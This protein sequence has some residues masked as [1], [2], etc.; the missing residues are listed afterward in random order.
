MPTKKK[1][2]KGLPNLNMYNISALG[3]GQHECRT[4]LNKT[5]GSS[6]ILTEVTV[7]VGLFSNFTLSILVEKS[8]QRNE[9]LLYR[10][11]FL[12]MN[13]TRPII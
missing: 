8:Q 4:H 10:L 11:N 2:K 6:Y 12:K 9:Y 7:K 5:N 1:L 13:K 3:A